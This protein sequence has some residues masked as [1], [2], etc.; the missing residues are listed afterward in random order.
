MNTHT[1]GIFEMKSWDEQTWDGQSA[2]DVSGAKLTRARVTN[3]FQGEIEGEGTAEML[4][5]YQEDG[6]ASYVGLEHVAGRLGSRSG[7]F[8]LQSHGTFEADAAKTTWSIVP[9]SGTG[10]LVG[11]RGQGSYVAHHGES[12]V[13]FT[14]DYSF[15]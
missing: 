1:S 9:D 4:M 3:L 12:R 8:V 14:L 6:S 15:E 5:V 10:D 11:L 13:P 7:S 2:R